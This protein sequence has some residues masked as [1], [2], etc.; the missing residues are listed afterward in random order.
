MSSVNIHNAMLL[1]ILSVIQAG[2]LLTSSLNVSTT[3]ARFD[4]FQASGSSSVIFIHDQS[5]RGSLQCTELGSFFWFPY[6]FCGDRSAVIFF[7]YQYH[8]YRKSW[9]STLMTKKGNAINIF[10]C[11][12]LTGINSNIWL[13]DFWCSIEPQWFQFQGEGD[14]DSTEEQPAVSDGN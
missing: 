4:C 5:S 3:L 11:T 2:L 6:R 10:P 9:H 7:R 14:K 8:P 13:F 12:L 1:K